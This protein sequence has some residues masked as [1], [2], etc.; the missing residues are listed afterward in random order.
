VDTV[1]TVFDGFCNT[2]NFEDCLVRVV[3][4]GGDADTTG[5]LAGQL[6]GA[7]YGV[8][9]IPARWL[10]KLDPAVTTAIERLT[11]QL[12]SLSSAIP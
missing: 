3:N 8:R 1:Q 7:L 2:G 6:A 5:A 9:G 11:P 10:K 12:L 4:R